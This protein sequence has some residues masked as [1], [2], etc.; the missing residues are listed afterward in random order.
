MRINLIDRDRTRRLRRQTR[1]QRRQSGQTGTTRTLEIAV[2]RPERPAKHI[3]RPAKQAPAER[4]AKPTKAARR[5]DTPRTQRASRPSIQ[6]PTAPRVRRINWRRV[7]LK[8][9][10]VFALGGLIGLV[11]YTWNSTQFYVYGAEIAGNRHLSADVIYQMAG[12]NEMNIFWI[13]SDRVEEAIGQLNGIK[14]VQVQCGLPAQVRIQVEE[15]EPVVMWRMLAQEHDWWL[16]E[17]GVVLPYHGDVNDTI[18]V[19]DSSSRQLHEGDRLEPSGIV[20]SVQRLA[21][22]V[23]NAQVFFYEPERG[24]SFVQQGQNG[25][26]EWPVYVGTSVDLPRKIG[27]L[28]TL[29]DYL[30]A[31]DIHPRYIDVRWADHPVYGA[32]NSAAIAPDG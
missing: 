30:A 25:E 15:R 5:A 1:R 8:V 26:Q 22:A 9:A 19:V 17:E 31:H 3:G 28:R 32:P 10:A 23:P 4:Q 2:A 14:S 12:I 7:M 13:R 6:S 29:S 18:F 27:I 24:L 21:A 16:D 11:G 20:D